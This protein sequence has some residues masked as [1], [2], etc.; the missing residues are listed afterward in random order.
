MTNKHPTESIC[1]WAKA[2]ADNPATQKTPTLGRTFSYSR[3]TATDGTIRWRL[4][5]RSTVDRRIF[6][7]TVVSRDIP[8][9]ARALRRA[10][11]DLRER[12]DAYDLEMMGM[13]A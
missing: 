12:V 5:R 2:I 3:H 6:M 11:N 1:L 13:A 7:S 8:A 4:F 10:R 9:A